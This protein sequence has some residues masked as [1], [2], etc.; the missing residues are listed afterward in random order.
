MNAQEVEDQRAALQAVGQDMDGRAIPGH[1]F[2]IQ[3]DSAV[4][5]RFGDLL[6]G[7][8]HERNCITGT[9][10]RRLGASVSSNLRPEKSASNRFAPNRQ[11]SP[12]RTEP[13]LNL[14]REAEPI[15]S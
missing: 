2:A 6:G 13:I 4:G 9:P 1:E 7:T 14:T 15:S 10:A 5:R 11:F 8:G 3:P 12:A